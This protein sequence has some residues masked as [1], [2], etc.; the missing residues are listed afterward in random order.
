M[1]ALTFLLVIHSLLSIARLETERPQPNA[2]DSPRPPA[3]SAAKAFAEAEEMHERWEEGSL[4]QAIEKYEAAAA[5]WQAV[6]PVKA[7]EALRSAGDIYFILSD[8]KQSLSYYERAL[9]I[10]RGSSDRGG[11]LEALNSIGYVYIYLGESQKALG[12]LTRV[13][14]ECKRLSS[15][16]PGGVKWQRLAAQAFN[17]IGEVYYAFGDLK[18]SI[19]M[20]TRALDIWTTEDDRRGRALAHLNLGYSYTDSG[21]LKEATEHYRQSLALWQEV[22]DRRGEALARTALGGIYSFLGDKQQALDSHSSALTLFR[23]MGNHQGEASAINGV[24]QAYEDLN[25]Y[26][27]ALENYKRALDLYQVIGNRDF[28]A[29]NKYYIGRVYFSMKEAWSARTFYTQALDLSR[30]V[31]DRQIEAH[32]LNGLGMIYSLE[33]DNV[34]ARKN[35]RGVLNLYERISDRRGQAYALN[36]I[37]RL[38]YNS[39]EPQRALAHFRLALPLIRATEDQRGEALILFNIANAERDG[40][41]FGEALARIKES[42]AIIEASRAKVDSKNLRMSYFAKAHK[43]YEL[44]IDLLMQL[45]KRQPDAG[46]DS[47]AFLASERARSRSL[48]DTLTEERIEV[49]RGPYNRLLARE[50]ELQHQLDAKTEYRTR[51]LS[52]NPTK[53][54]VSESAEEIRALSL[55]Y[56]EV[57]SRIREQHPR[58]AAITQ[59]NQFNLKDIQ[60]ELR[61]NNTLLLEFSL[62][63]ERSYLWA[64]SPTSINGYELPS[65]STIESKAGKVYDLLTARQL[66]YEG[67]APQRQGFIEGSDS[68]YSTEAAALS[69]TLLGPVASQLGSRRLLIVTDGAL[70]YIPFEALPVPKQPAGGDFRPSS[71]A[72][73]RTAEQKLLIDDHEIIGMPSASIL[74]AIRRGKARLTPAAKTVAVLADP[75]FDKDDSRVRRSLEQEASGMPPRKPDDVYLQQ[76]MRDLNGEGSASAIPRLPASL[77]EAKAI[78]AITPRDEGTITTGF[79]ASR[80]RIMSEDIKHYRIV[81]FATHGILDNEHP[82]LSGIILSLVDE[83]GNPQNG[84]LR[85]RDIYGLDLPVDLVVLSACRTGLGRSVQGEGLIGLTRGFMYAGSKSVVASLWKVDDEATAELMKNFYASM[86]RDGLPPAEALRAAL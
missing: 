42:I 81:H 39:G 44:Y 23:L 6:D 13:S 18:G 1:L 76:A 12:Y 57:Q 16:S 77:R 55:E 61:D 70:Q 15:T 71:E 47:S 10:S 63:D 59:P 22:G 51:A 74:V 45:H 32:V 64:V 46:H 4:R 73:A 35:F 48:L 83:E 58:Y 86:L 27:A 53:A 84:Y 82:E 33:G 60:A 19:K 50:Q 28:E 29:L 54:E 24:A 8:Y 80:S 31:G 75:V 36:N 37:G 69:W 72:Q 40:G 67:K 25:D 11:E 38:Y 62:G 5:A 7:A 20:F 56:E 65:R 79:E 2:N 30:E 49:A 14:E 66:I 21:T 43:Y 34:N 78:L 41:N 3:E 9:K 85:L 17:N 26:Q 68:N 52:G